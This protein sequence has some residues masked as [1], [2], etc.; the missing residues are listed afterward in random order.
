MIKQSNSGASSGFNPAAAAFAPACRMTPR[1]VA[2]SGRALTVWVASLG[3]AAAATAQD[4]AIAPAAP[5]PA[6]AQAPAQAPPEAPAEPQAQPSAETTPAEGDAAQADQPDSTKPAEGDGQ[7]YPVSGLELRYRVPHP[8]VPSAEELMNRLSVKLTK[9]EEG[10]VAP[11][12]GAPTET[13]RLADI[14]KN[15]PVTLYGSAVREISLVI[16]GELQKR[17]LLVVTVAPNA[18]DIEQVQPWTDMRD[19]EGG[20]TA[21]RMD[22]TLGVVRQLRTIASGDRALTGSRVDNPAHAWIKRKSP[23]K[24]SRLTPSLPVDVFQDSFE[25]EEPQDADMDADAEADAAT[26]ADAARPADAAQP[27][28]AAAATPEGEPSA[29]EPG[30]TPGEGVADTTPDNLPPDA[31]TDQQRDL[32]NKP[33]L[34]EYIYRLNRF[35][36]RRVDVAIS[37]LDEQRS[38][39]ILLDYLVSEN[40]PWS[41]YAQISNTGTSSTSEWRERFGFSHSQLT[42]NDDVLRLD[43][44][45]SSF[46]ETNALVGSY[47]FPIFSERLRGRAYGSWNEFTASDV[48]Q[49]GANFEGEGWNW[50]TELIWNVYQRGPFFLDLVGG[51]RTQYVSTTSEL[52]DVTGRD[53]FFLPYAGV[54]M[55]RNTDK[56]SLYGSVNIETTASGV[57]GVDQAQIEN[58]GRPN[59]DKNFTVLQYD[60]GTS[61]F[62]E[63]LLYPNAVSAE[64]GATLAHELAFSFKGQWAFENRLIPTSQDVVGGLYTVRGYPESFVAGDSTFI[65]SAEYRFHVPR[66]F[67]VETDPGKTPLFGQ[68]FRFRP[69]QAYG[70]ADWDFIL[71]AFTDVGRAINSRREAVERDETLWGAG[72]GGELQ[73][74]RNFSVRVDWAMALQNAKADNS[75]DADVVTVGSNRFHIVATL[76]F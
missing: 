61:F 27:A 48:G 21:L 74:L 55:D 62:L 35:P 1:L 53:T 39:E 69:Q 49:A 41:A 11:R 29:A 40:R 23:I 4:A 26:P 16:L 46:D 30:A 9:L 22:I 31:D 64:D 19:L 28:D 10:Y 63:P 42:G 72:V 33:I 34:D 5:E 20:Q 54:R 18:D 71:R 7:P 66:A 13:L 50:G 57:T 17:G 36:G 14:G 3:L 70:Q 37:A 12:A 43:F 76:L 32:I 58:L 47:E 45:T 8:S 15:G 60:F 6:P 75:A 56:W 68:P 38:N 65:A 25:D 52:T 2:V 51:F 44:I 67:G 59:P 24:P 73:I